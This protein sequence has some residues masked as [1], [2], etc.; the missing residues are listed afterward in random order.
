MP[1]KIYKNR[2]GWVYRGQRTEDRRQKTEDRRQKTE[3]CVGRVSL[4]VTRQDRGTC[5]IMHII[6]L[7]DVIISKY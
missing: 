2:G 6:L 5:W 1:V 4:S 7:F 3:S